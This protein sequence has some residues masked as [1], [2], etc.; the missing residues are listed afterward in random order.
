MP[1]PAAKPAFHLASSHDWAIISATPEGQSILREL[2]EK[3]QVNQP[4]YRDAE[5]LANPRAA[6]TFAKLRDGNHEVIQYIIHRA[7]TDHDLS[8]Q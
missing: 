7:N 6:E 5:I 2:L 4:L 3:F 1:A 8:P